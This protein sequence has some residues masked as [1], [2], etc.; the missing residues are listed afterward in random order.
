V[1]CVYVGVIEQAIY[2]APKSKMNHG[3]HIYMYVCVCVSTCL[4]LLDTIA[5]LFGNN[6]VK[7]SFGGARPTPTPS[8]RSTPSR[9]IP[10]PINET[11]RTCAAKTS[12]SPE[13]YEYRRL[14]SAQYGNYPTKP[15]STLRPQTIQRIIIV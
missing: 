3:A 12:I 4:C 8:L 7:F 13:E 5:S 1:I 15:G 6:L 10:S 9:L 11:Y 14:R 2:I